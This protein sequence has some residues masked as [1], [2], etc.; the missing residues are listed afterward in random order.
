MKRKR[1]LLFFGGITLLLLGYVAWCGRSMYLSVP[2][3]ELTQLPPELREDA[4]EI[5]VARGLT[6]PD[7]FDLK[8]LGKLLAN[9]YQ[10]QPGPFVVTQAFGGKLVVMRGRISH[11]P[12]EDNVYFTQQV[13]VWLVDPARHELNP[14][15]LQAR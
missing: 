2:V 9:P 5:I 11:Y 4:R 1:A 3:P 6:R 13:D 14:R 8:I 10:T 12:Q 7:R 15:Q